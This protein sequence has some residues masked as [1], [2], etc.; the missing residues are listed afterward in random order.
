MFLERLIPPSTSHLI[1][2]YLKR[3][4]IGFLFCQQ[5]Q[6]NVNREIQSW[7]LKSV[8]RWV[9][10]ILEVPISACILGNYPI[11]NKSSVETLGSVVDLISWQE[12]ETMS[13]LQWAEEEEQSTTEEFPPLTYAEQITK[14]YIP[15]ASLAEMC[16]VLQHSFQSRPESHFCVSSATWSQEHESSSHSVEIRTCS[17]A[18]VKPSAQEPFHTL[19]P[20]TLKVELTHTYEQKSWLLNKGTCVCLLR[21]MPWMWLH[22]RPSPWNYTG[23]LHEQIMGMIH[24]LM[25]WGILIDNSFT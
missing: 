25:V 14:L 6:W 13:H 12:Q 18:I 21:L 1:I 22:L 10:V 16:Q 9:Q 23:K 4:N 15:S 5:K 24:S 19:R 11:W 2:R 8:R 17:E 7:H 3:G 20:P